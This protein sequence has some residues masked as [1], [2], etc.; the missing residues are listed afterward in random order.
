[1]DFRDWSSVLQI[2]IMAY[3]SDFASTTHA[4]NRCKTVVQSLHHD[5]TV[6]LRICRN[7]PGSGRHSKSLTV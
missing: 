2:I 7:Y 1:M 4:Q 5:H 6:Q 3:F